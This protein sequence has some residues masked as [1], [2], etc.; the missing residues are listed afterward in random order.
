MIESKRRRRETAVVGAASIA[1]AMFASLLGLAACTST[2]VEDIGQYADVPMNKVYPYPSDD[3]LA[4]RTHSVSI[5]ARTAEGVD[6][7]RA[8]ATQDLIRLRLEDILSIAGATL[9][10]DDGSEFVSDLPARRLDLVVRID[11]E[12]Y[13]VTWTDPTNWLFQSEEEMAQK[14]GTCTHRAAVEIVFSVVDPA[15]PT[16][17]PKDRFTLRHTGETEVETLNQQCPYPDE[18]IQGLFDTVV[19]DALAC[20]RVPLQNAFAPR[21]H[22]LG[23]RSRPDDDIHLFETSLGSDQGA[24]EGV[25]VEVY[26]VQY[27]TGADDT[28][29]AEEHRIATGRTTNRIQAD[30]SWIRVDVADAHQPLLQGD[31]VQPV[32]RDANTAGLNPFG[33][34]SD[35]FSRP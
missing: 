5:E 24:A 7:T 17:R 28:R 23:Q 14:P 30:T 8:Q 3:E 2:R 35:I 20:V 31:V 6:P 22:I 25:E 13:S 10:N 27:S 29:V 26:R 12:E 34:C 9:L 21:G 18:A 19:D 32:Y 1:S 4:E 11:H 16:A 15:R 33:G